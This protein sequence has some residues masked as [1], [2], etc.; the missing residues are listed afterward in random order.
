MELGVVEQ[1][2]APDEDLVLGVATMAIAAVGDANFAPMTLSLLKL[3][4]RPMDE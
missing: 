2:V 1:V 4:Q 3:R